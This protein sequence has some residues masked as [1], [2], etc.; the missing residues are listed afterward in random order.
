MINRLENLE[1]SAIASKRIFE[2]PES[3][4]LVPDMNPTII[5][6]FFTLDK[7]L[8]PTTLLNIQS[9][10]A[11]PVSFITKINMCKSILTC[12]VLLAYSLRILL[13]YILYDY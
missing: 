13:F 8:R 6:S 1:S 3:P 7:L 12:L 11:K 2:D 5:L 4:V 10:N 9:L